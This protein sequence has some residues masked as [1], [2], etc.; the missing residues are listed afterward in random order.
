MQQGLLGAA[1]EPSLPSVR[2]NQTKIHQTQIAWSD[3]GFSVGEKR[4]LTGCTGTCAAGSL[5]AIIGPSG[6]GKTTL[7]NILA[8]RL[9]PS[10]GSVAVDG[11]RIQAHST[12]LARQMAYVTQEDALYPHC[13]PREALIFSAQ[14]R[15]PSHV[16]GVEKR[17]KA[18]EMLELLGLKSCADT[19]IGSEM[20]RGISGGEKKRTSIGVELV[21]DPGLLLLDEPT[22]GLDSF[23]AVTVVRTLQALAQ[24]G[25]TVLCTIH[26][27]SSEVFALFDRVLLLGG[28]TQMFSGPRE[29]IVMHFSQLGIDCP[30]Q[31]NTA[32]T[33]L[34]IMQTAAPTTLE[35][36]R[37]AAAEKV[38]V[39]PLSGEADGLRIQPGQRSRC[40]QLGALLVRELRGL[41][42]NKPALYA[43]FGMT[44]ILN[45]LFAF[46]F[47]GAGMWPTQGADL[48]EEA[49]FLLINDSISNHF[50]AI[51]QIL[52]GT[53]F[54]A[55][56]PMMLE[57]PLERPI[58][59]REYRTA[60]YGAAV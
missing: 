2:P 12:D 53:M 17:R 54:G 33:L 48:S 26:Q 22:S 6:A 25:C 58:F 49:R 55:A 39:S 20:R 28:G 46:I 45:L 8:G 27:P 41:W 30:P 19:L 10:S 51:T 13:T 44:G 42:R 7:L 24:S 50:G 4:I 35:K 3:V 52:I 29:E 32:D 31:H 40:M 43:R 5:T 21:T 14:L 57:F 60:H 18:D 9:S 34:Y 59:I 36:I 47:K 16:N 1:T 56:Q 38:A 37:V 23:A 11:R 15:L